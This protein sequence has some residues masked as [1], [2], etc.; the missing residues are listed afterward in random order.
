MKQLILNENI[1]L[2][3]DAYKHTHWKM[4]PENVQYTYA[5]LESRGVTDKGVPSETVFFGLQYYIK[6]YMMGQVVSEENIT[7]AEALLKQ[8]FNYDYFNQKGWRYILD[9]YDGYLPLR[10][11]S[12]DEGS[13]VP[14]LNVLLTVENTDPKLPW[15]TTFI[16][17][18]LMRIWYPIS[19]ATTSFGI[20][21][22]IRKYQR[23]SGGSDF[24]DYHL[25]DFGSRGVSSK[26]SA[27]IGGMSHLIVFK[28]SDTLEGV[29]YAKAYYNADFVAG[30]V[31][32]S[33]HSETL[34]FG[35]EHEKEAYQTMLDVYPEGLLS[36]VSDTY[37]INN[38]V[39]NIFGRELRDKILSRKGKLVIRPDSGYP[40]HICTVILKSL[41]KN[42]GGKINNNGYISLNPKVGV[43][44]GDFIRYGMID[45]IF[46]AITKEGFSTDNVVFGMGGALLQQVNRDT[47]KFAIKNSAVKY[48]DNDE[49]VGIAKNPITDPNKKSKKGIL[50]LIKDSDNNYLTQQ[51]N[52]KDEPS[53]LLKTKFLNGY[54]Q[55]EESYEEIRR[56]LNCCFM[57]E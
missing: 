45:D 29:K 55:L 56:R 36:I 57:R 13:V 49:W 38:A 53:D 37:D 28:G 22:L 18:L 34:L 40:P 5:Y 50:Q 23:L 24:L 3:T 31:A 12:V 32:A 30:S 21:K 4:I 48:R 41:Y 2:D 25:N 7:E 16:E 20:K 14:C 8:V 42:F 35:E 6:R 33:E 11:K 19:V 1:I 9:K 47:F 39:D 46:S 27:G 51:Y 54:I 43:I 44:Y 17:T 10:I 15:L 26:E 52:K